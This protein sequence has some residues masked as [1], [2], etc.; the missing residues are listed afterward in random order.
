MC[1]F[2]DSTD[3]RLN[4]DEYSAICI[5]LVDGWFILKGRDMFDLTLGSILFFVIIF[6]ATLSWLVQTAP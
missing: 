3:Q 4:T 5:R 6:V 1:F 2:L